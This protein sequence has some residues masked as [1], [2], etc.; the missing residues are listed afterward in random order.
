M[1]CLNKLEFVFIKKTSTSQIREIMGIYR[2]AG[3]LKKQDTPDLFRRMLK[4]SFFYLI[5]VKKTNCYF[6]AE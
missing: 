5:C 6:A 4:K 2:D 1:E 3:W